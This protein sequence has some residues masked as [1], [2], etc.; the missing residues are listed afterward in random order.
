[1]AS[2]EID[3][4]TGLP[5]FR[6]PPRHPFGLAPIVREGFPFIDDPEHPLYAAMNSNWEGWTP[7]AAMREAVRIA[8][9][10]R[11]ARAD[12]ASHPAYDP[13]YIVNEQASPPAPV[14]PEA[15]VEQ[16]GGKRR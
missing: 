3:P 16:A 14:V 1:M 10:K 2:D 7:E 4:E 9:E 15:P 6:L 8:K 12:S 5:V 11:A 13:G